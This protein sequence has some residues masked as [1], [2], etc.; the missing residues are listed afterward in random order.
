M[1]R[2]AASATGFELGLPRTDGDQLLEDPVGRDPDKPIASTA[3][4]RALLGRLGV[5]GESLERRRGSGRRRSRPPARSPAAARL[6]V[7]ESS[8]DQLRP[9]AARS[10]RAVPVP[11]EPPASIVQQLPAVRRVAWPHRHARPPAP[12]SPA[13]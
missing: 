10:W 8:L 7:I 9:P 2:T 13:R 4:T 12:R 11:A 1:A 5:L 3:A 6:G